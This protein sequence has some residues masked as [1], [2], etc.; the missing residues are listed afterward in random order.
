LII[1]KTVQKYGAQVTIRRNNQIA[2]ATSILDLLSLGA[3]Q[4]TELI[5]SATDRQAEEV[6]EALSK[7]FDVEFEVE[8]KD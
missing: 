2:D 3:G 1:V 5:L 6:V 7:L 4:G 8:Y